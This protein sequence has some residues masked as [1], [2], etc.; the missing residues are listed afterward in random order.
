[1]PSEFNVTEILKRFFEKDL[2]EILDY[3]IEDKEYYL[4]LRVI[5]TICD[6]YKRSKQ[7]GIWTIIVRELIGKFISSMFL[8]LGYIV[9]VFGYRTWHDKFAKTRVI[10]VKYIWLEFYF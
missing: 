2:I 3:S 1:M 7:L 10:S 9:R 8:M 4:S 6:K 5:G